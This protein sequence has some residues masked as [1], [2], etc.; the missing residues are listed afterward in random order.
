MRVTYVVS[1]DTLKHRI[2]KRLGSD[3]LLCGASVSA[4][5]HKNVA[6]ANSTWYLSELL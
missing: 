4:L 6:I 1:S 2:I 3:E 5:G